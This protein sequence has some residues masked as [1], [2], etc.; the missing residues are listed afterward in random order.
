M[1]ASSFV[2]S[3]EVNV[4]DVV[5]DVEHDEERKE[6]LWGVSSE[7]PALYTKPRPLQASSGYMT[8]AHPCDVEDLLRNSHGPS[9]FNQ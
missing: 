1:L 7:R 4:R 3:R 5:G 9:P 6:E 2:V 8:Q